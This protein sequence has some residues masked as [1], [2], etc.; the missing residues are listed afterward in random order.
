MTSSWPIPVTVCGAL[1]RMGQRVVYAAAQH[2]RLALVGA[3]E[4]P[5][6][7]DLGKDAGILT[8]LGEIGVPIE[9]DLAVA[10]RDSKVYIDFTTPTRSWPTWASP[11]AWAWPR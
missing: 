9:G 6:H 4:R 5:G 7:P 3:C 11:S 2:E 8:G 10:A 1:G